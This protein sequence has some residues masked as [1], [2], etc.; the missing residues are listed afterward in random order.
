MSHELTAWITQLFSDPAL[1]GMGHAQ[2]VDDLNLGLGWM[3][4]GLARLVR[5]QRIVV[6]GSYRGFAPMVFARA[7]L[8]N[9]EDGRVTFIDPSM[10]DNF[11]QDPVR[12][13]AHFASYGIHNIDHHCMT[14][15]QFVESAAWRD[16]GEVGV[17][18]VDGFHSEE[19]ARF[20]HNA[21]AQLIPTDGYAL[22]HDSV[23]ERLSRIY[24]ANNPYLHTVKRYMD[25]LR[26]DP[27]WEVLELPYGD[28]LCIV[29]RAGNAA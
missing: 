22:F 15:Q 29:R 1:T 20:D 9:A 28:G 2:R 13:Q 25:T 4:Y 7:L 16:P 14:T 23:R 17:L 18:L 26:R 10:A 21:F 24:D 19:Q 11:W 27:A 12:V 8:D 3:Y 6:I 5:A